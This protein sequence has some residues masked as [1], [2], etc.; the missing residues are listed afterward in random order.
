MKIERFEDIEAQKHA[1]IRVSS[2]TI[3]RRGAETQR[4]TKN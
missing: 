3:S 4:R 1:R 2:G